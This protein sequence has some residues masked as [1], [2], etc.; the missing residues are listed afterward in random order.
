MDNSR[1]V[2]DGGSKDYSPFIPWYNIRKVHRLKSPI[3][4]QMPAHEYIEGYEISFFSFVVYSK[5][6]KNDR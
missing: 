3:S 1:I 2:K 4:E 6:Y 5:G